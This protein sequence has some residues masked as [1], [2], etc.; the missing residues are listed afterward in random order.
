MSAEAVRGLGGQ[1]EAALKRAASATGVDFDFLLRTAK[2]ESGFNAGARAGTSSAA[3]LFQFVEQT[4]LSTLKRH[5][6]AHGYARYSELIQQGGDGRYHVAGGPEARQ[7]VLDLRFDPHA[8]SVMA[9]DLANDHAAYLRGRVGREPTGGE[10][11]AAH[12]LGPHGSA[13]LI[14]AYSNYPNAAAATFFPD[15][16]AANRNVFY[17]DGRPLSVAQVY[18][19]LSNTGGAGGAV[20]GAVDDPGEAAFAAYA[21][22]RRTERERQ[23]AMLV[24]MLLSND[25]ASTAGPFAA[26]Y[27]ADILTLLSRAR[28]EDGVK[29]L[30]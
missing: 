2:R 1:V 26:M 10:L 24:S 15:A 3:G 7:A 13:K 4:W 12:F 6:A 28:D 29:G 5:G 9:A 21:G 8:A 19:D 11:Y 17:R 18:A 27:S 25:A 23:E 14:E 22:A 30:F 16:A 20:G